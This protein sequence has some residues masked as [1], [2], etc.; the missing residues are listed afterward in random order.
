MMKEMERNER[1]EKE[2]REV[3]Y[4][5]EPSRVINEDE[6]LVIDLLMQ[7]HQ[8]AGQYGR[9]GQPENEIHL[10]KLVRM[11]TDAYESYLE[12]EKHQKNFLKHFGGA[13]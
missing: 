6:K 8:R 7:L 1:E 3:S 2:R 10:N 4:E 9:E 5:I 12:E 13:K 11:L